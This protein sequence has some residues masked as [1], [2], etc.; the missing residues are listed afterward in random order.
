MTGPTYVNVPVFRLTY[1]H[2]NM[3]MFTIRPPCGVEKSVLLCRN[4]MFQSVCKSRHDNIAVPQSVRATH[5]RPHSPLNPQESIA[6]VEK[7]VQ[8]T[9]HS[10]IQ[11]SEGYKTES[12]QQT[13]SDYRTT[14]PT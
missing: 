1:I 11:R 2:K 14:G 3:S 12:Y 4:G 5:I 8:Y 9:Y 7:I 6:I 10:E 13:N